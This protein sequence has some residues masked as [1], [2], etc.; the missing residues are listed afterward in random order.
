MK[1]VSLRLLIAIVAVL[2]A[3]AGA[4]AQAIFPPDSNNAALRYWTALTEMRYTFEDETT[5]VLLS[6]TI[7]GEASWDENKIG[8]IL[9]ANADAIQAMQRGAKLPECNWGLDYRLGARTPVGMVK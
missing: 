5:R 9:D 3:T 6:A 4:R 7:T 8:P 2:A 1:S